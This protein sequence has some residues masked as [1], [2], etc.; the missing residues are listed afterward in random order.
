MA[1]W[2]I[3][4][5]HIP[6]ISSEHVPLAEFPADFPTDSHKIRKI[7]HQLTTWQNRPIFLRETAWFSG[8]THGFCSGIPFNQSA[9]RRNVLGR[10]WPRTARSWVGA[11]E[12][13]AWCICPRTVRAECRPAWRD[14]RKGP[15][16]SGLVGLLILMRRELWN[17]EHGWKW[18]IYVDKWTHWIGPL[19]LL[20]ESLQRN[21]WFLPRGFRFQGSHQ[22]YEGNSYWLGI[23]II[24]QE[25]TYLQTNHCHYCIDRTFSIGQIRDMMGQT[26]G[27]NGGAQPSRTQSTYW[28]CSLSS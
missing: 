6:K 12:W 14:D 28:W 18:P 23:S 17:G 26:Y 19:V 8:K 1:S 11:E 13:W 15:G 24:T 22:F 25:R 21:P 7:K 9:L 10:P 27:S 16:E 3:Q 2:N 5:S 4:L 20:G